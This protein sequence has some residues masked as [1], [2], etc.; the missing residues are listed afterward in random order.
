M[1][2]QRQERPAAHP[3]TPADQVL[4]RF[5][6]AGAGEGE[7]SWGQRELYQVIEKKPT[8]LPIGTA[9]PLPAGSTVEGV[10]EDLRFV[11]SSYPSMRT[12][13]RLDADGAKQVVAPS[14]EIVLEV[15]EAAADADPAEVADEVWWRYADQDLDLT[16][17]WPLRMAV[18]R[19]RGVLT[20]RVWV[21]C[22]LVTDGTGARVVVQ[23]L[24]GRDSSGSSAALS[25][26][27]Q[28]RWQRSPAGQ[29]QSER[30]LHYW[31]QVLR[32][33]PARRFPER[34]ETPR[35]RYWEARFNSPATYLAVRMISARTGVELASVLLGLY[36]AA[37]GRVMRTNPVML[38]LV[39]NNRFR[40]GLARTVSS[41]IQPGLCVLDIPDATV[42]E[43]V[44][45][46]RRRALVAYKNAYHDPDLRESM[47]AQVNLE[48]GEQVDIECAFNDRRLKPVEDGGPPPSAEQVRAALPDT[49]FQWL[50]G[51]DHRP[52]DRLYV[53]IDDVPD[54]VQLTIATDLNYVSPEDLE[55][56]V[57]GMEE[58]A[59]AAAL[60]PATR[61]RPP[62]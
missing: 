51:Q 3:T 33:V 7:L 44:V 1:V 54:T 29:R 6:G 38:V 40:P 48:R 43:L 13:L 58:L 9:V 15:V 60:D 22:H 55:A 10:A 47:M 56:C 53:Y 41:I 59:V 27:E 14:G 30:A 19:H 26:L 37:L 18:I 4:V 23:E 12:R 52:Y 49:A 28:A 31:E 11:M 61:V 21:M 32:T 39:V 24:A 25:P 35:P 20:H 17:E 8:W 34:T 42:D 16:T 36:A 57:R 5:E 50:K 46:T 45:Y 2:D 62:A